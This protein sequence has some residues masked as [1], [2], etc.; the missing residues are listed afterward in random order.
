M[1]PLDVL[2]QLQLLSLWEIY[3]QQ[4]LRL[5]TTDVM[6]K[7]IIYGSELMTIAYQY[8]L[9]KMKFPNKDMSFCWERRHGYLEIRDQT[10]RNYINHWIL[11]K[12]VHI[13]NQRH[14]M[15]FKQNYDMA[16][17]RIALNIMIWL[18]PQLGY[19]VENMASARITLDIMIWLRPQ[20]W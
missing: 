13:S 6:S 11:F 10:D 19:G 15:V 1:E 5:G 3:S 7:S 14:G 12:Q 16:S 4:D 18:W 9:M 20:L 8:W 2:K 17:A